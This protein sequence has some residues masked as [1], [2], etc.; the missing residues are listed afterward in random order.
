V[1]GTPAGAAPELLEGGGGIL[2]PME[3][4]R[5]M[6]DAILKVVS[7]ASPDWRALSDA[8]Y[9][10]A[11]RYTWDDATDRFED[12]LNRA[13]AAARGNSLQPVGV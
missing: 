10:T 2:V 3:N 8:A 11:S 6:A 4:A 1:V 13:V 5:A 9:A 7:M 12:A